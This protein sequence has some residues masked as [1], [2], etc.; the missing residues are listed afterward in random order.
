MLGNI[1]E[2]IKKYVNVMKIAKKPTIKEMKE[3]LRIVGVGFLV[4]GIIGF[5]FYMIS[6]FAGA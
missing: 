2:T 3:I 5:I 1:K 4:M 6:V